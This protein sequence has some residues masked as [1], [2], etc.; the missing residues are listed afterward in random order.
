MDR[1]NNRNILRLIFTVCLGLFISTSLQAKKF[2]FMNELGRKYRIK[3]LTEQKIFVNGFF[4]SR[5]QGMN[6]A[7][8]EVLKLT[9]KYAL[10]QGKYNHYDKNLDL[11]ESFKLTQIYNTQFFRNTY[12]QMIIS[13]KYFMPAI[14][15]V[16]TFPKGDI[17]VGDTWIAKG[18][19]IHEGLVDRTHRIK[20]NI[21]VF[22]RY[23]GDEKK[24]GKTLSK[25]SID[26]HVIYY[27]KNDKEMVSF[28]GYSHTTYYWDSAIGAPHSYHE[29]L[30]FMV[31]LKN[32][33][34][35]LYTGTSE[36]IV[37]VVSDLAKKAKEELV[38][39][40]SKQIKND[41]G[42]KVKSTNDGIIV[43]LANILFD[44]N[45]TTLKKKALGGLKRLAELLRKYPHLD[46]E[47]YGHTDSTGRASYNITLSELRAKSV[48]DYLVSEGIASHRMSYMGYG[49]TK[50]VAPNTTVSGRAK[51]RRVEIK[52][53]TKE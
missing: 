29:D 10:Y 11:N 12:G 30:S 18:E 3:N 8:L 39:A 23:L 43:N 50:P 21:D 40:I 44:V 15:G 20:F 49:S 47:V 22:Y 26:Y 38:S 19:E 41:T 27:P 16:P 45:K 24:D 37:E 4:H 52:I 25:I 7:T 13:S 28:T 31:T 33:Q 53:I 36:A 9:N 48:A 51:N 17:E 2:E 32:G 14:R 1:Q 34:T 35:I 46:I 5:V 42:M 6:K